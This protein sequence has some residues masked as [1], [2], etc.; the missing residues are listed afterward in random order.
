MVAKLPARQRR[1]DLEDMVL[2]ISMIKPD[3]GTMKQ[4]TH[5][6]S[7]QLLWNLLL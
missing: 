6:H 3:G 4:G 7:Q 5:N 1:R 2:G